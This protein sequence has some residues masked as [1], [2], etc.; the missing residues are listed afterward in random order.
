MKEYKK[1]ELVPLYYCSFHSP[2]GNAV[3]KAKRTTNQSTYPT[4]TAILK[5]LINQ[6]MLLH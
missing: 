4:P 5:P 6:G 1:D 2:A 3:T